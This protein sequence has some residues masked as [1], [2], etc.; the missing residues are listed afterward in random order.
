MRACVSCESTAVACGPPIMLAC[1]SCESGEAAGE[2]VRGEAT[3]EAAGDPAGEAVV[4][5]T[6]VDAMGEAAE[7][8]CT[9]AGINLRPRPEPHPARA[10]HSTGLKGLR[11][12]LDL[13]LGVVSSATRFVGAA[14]HST[15]LA[16]EPGIVSEPG[17]ATEPV[18]ESA[19][20]TASSASVMVAASCVTGAQESAGAAEGAAEG[21]ADLPTQ[22]QAPLQCAAVSARFRSSLSWNT[23]PESTALEEKVLRPAGPGIL[24]KT[25]QFVFVGQPPRETHPRTC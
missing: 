16:G 19:V 2:N 7:D 3:G 17:P 9:K 23:G 20:D 21:P 4:L 10:L 25:K 18:G 13:A 22:A 14:R 1:V 24:R 6:A 8:T 5:G 15:G 12:E 11:G